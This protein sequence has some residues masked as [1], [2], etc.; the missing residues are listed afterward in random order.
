M[1]TIHTTEWRNLPKPAISGVAQL[2]NAAGA[3]AAL[4]VMQDFLPVTRSAVVEG[5]ENV[6]IAARF[7]KV[8]ECDQYGASVTIDV[9][10]NPQAAE[11]LAENLARTTSPQD[12]VWAVFGM[13]ADKDMASVAK[14]MNRHIDRWFV[15]GLPKPRGAEALELM[16][17]MQEGG[18]D[19]GKVVTCSSVDDAIRK[20]L[21]ESLTEG[22]E[23]VKIIG[24]GSF[25]TVTGIIESL[26]HDL[27]EE[28]LAAG[29]VK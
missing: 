21:K 13:F 23:T 27:R 7:E 24:F 12:K 20:A 3:L 15:T 4:A 9:G 14:I 1:A 19:M 29:Q 8:K 18:V 5:L 16:D 25:V 28:Q 6:V 10:H 2:Q 17:A 26:K 11:V 22:P